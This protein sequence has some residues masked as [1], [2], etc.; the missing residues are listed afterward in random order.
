MFSATFEEL[1][2]YFNAKKRKRK[3]KS[4]FTLRKNWVALHKKILINISLGILTG[5]K[6]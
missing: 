1:I 2:D 4:N 5:R 3:N 6:F